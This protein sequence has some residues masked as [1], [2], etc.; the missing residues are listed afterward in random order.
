[1][2]PTIWEGQQGMG[3]I[4]RI[5]VNSWMLSRFKPKYSPCSPTTAKGNK[6][7]ELSLSGIWRKL[8]ARSRK[9][10]CSWEL[11]SAIN[12]TES[13]SPTREELGSVLSDS[14]GVDPFFS[15]G[16]VKRFSCAESDRRLIKASGLIK[17]IIWSWC[18]ASPSK[19]GDSVLRI[20]PLIKWLEI[21]EVLIS[22]T[23]FTR[24]TIT[25]NL[26]P[27]QWITITEWLRL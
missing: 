3:V 14:S 27:S 23:P 1:M 22:S 21:S 10:S 6:P 9:I 13:S 4:C 5:S 7:T 8:L 2:F 24:L 18:C 12:S 26:C 25:P 19:S 11:N 16:S 17:E 15:K 20:A